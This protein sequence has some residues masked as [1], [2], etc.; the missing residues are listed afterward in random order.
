MQLPTQDLDTLFESAMQGLSP[1][2]LE[3]AREFKALIRSRKIKTPLQLLRVVLLYCGFKK[4]EEA[5]RL[6]TRV[7]YQKIQEPFEF[8]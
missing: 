1:D 8:G 4:F 3:K 6:D 2:V 7:G 5:Q